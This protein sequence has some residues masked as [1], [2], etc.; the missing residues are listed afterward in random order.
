MDA[1]IRPFLVAIIG[2]EWGHDRERAPSGHMIIVLTSPYWLQSRTSSDIFRNF[3]LATTLSPSVCVSNFTNCDISTRTRT[4][5]Y[6]NRSIRMT[7][8]GNACYSISLNVSSESSSFDGDDCITKR[9]LDSYWDTTCNIVTYL[10]QV[11]Y[12]YIIIILPVYPSTLHLMIRSITT[13]YDDNAFS[14]EI[15]PTEIDMASS[16]V[17]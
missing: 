17:T 14:G 7:D 15:D 2:P 13:V 11:T 9:E 5:V 8:T 6:M 3:L 4:S 10:L 16:L 12:R 1:P